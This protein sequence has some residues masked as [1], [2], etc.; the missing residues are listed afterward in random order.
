MGPG[1]LR[2]AR[3]AGRFVFDEEPLPE[4]RRAWLPDDRDFE[5][6][7]LR[8]LD[9]EVLRDEVLVLPVA[10]DRGGEDVR[11]AIRGNLRERH[12]RHT[13]PTPHAAPSP[14]RVRMPKRP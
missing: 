3:G 12:T 11:V 1:P 14:R 10:R 5:L 7:V 8:E 13:V 2:T 9:P 4:V 6:P